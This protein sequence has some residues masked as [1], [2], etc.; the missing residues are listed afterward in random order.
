MKVLTSF[1]P[2]TLLAASLLAT[3]ALAEPKMPPP[4][5]QVVAPSKR[6]KTQPPPEQTNIADSEKK[7]QEARAKKINEC[8]ADCV[9]QAQKKFP[10]TGSVIGG[11]VEKQRQQYIHNCQKGCI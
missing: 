11:A 4:S 2:A 8:K 1:I 9:R 5:K 3:S 10:A 7:K 6:S